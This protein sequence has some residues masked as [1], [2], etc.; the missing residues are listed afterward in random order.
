MNRFRI[1]LARVSA[2]AF[3]FFTPLSVALAA[4]PDTAGVDGLGATLLQI[5]YFIDRFLVPIVFALAFIVFIF[6]VYRTFILGATNE[7]KRQEGQKLVMYG[8]IGFFIMF[9]VWGLV[10]LLVNTLGFGSA[11]RPTLPTFSAP[12]AGGQSNTT[13]PF[14]GS[15]SQPSGTCQTDSQC[16]SGE[17][18]ELIS[19]TGICSGPHTQG[20]TKPPPSQ[21]P[22]RT[23]PVDDLNG[24]Y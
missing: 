10:N 19:G 2:S 6:G 23:P 14:G 5:V 9:S 7:E 8:L 21:L 1:Y 18:C 24:L 16:P 3:L 13:N 20:G 22:P 4:P 17:T 15:G 11:T 12:G